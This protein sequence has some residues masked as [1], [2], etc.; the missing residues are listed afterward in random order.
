MNKLLLF[1]AALLA[2]ATVWAQDAND[3]ALIPQPVSVN[4]A[5]GVYLLPHNPVIEAEGPALP[6][7]RLLG[8]KLSDA[9]GYAVM[10]KEGITKRTG[11]IRLQLSNQPASGKEGYQ[12]LVST[13]GISIHASAPAGLFYGMQTLWQLFPK[14]I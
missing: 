10:V 9:T 4:R 5:E 3:L 11:I 13:Q 7:A 8:K 2:G 14:E 1:A 12:L 6:I